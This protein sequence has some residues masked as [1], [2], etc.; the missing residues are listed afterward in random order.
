MN[1][2]F[3]HAL[4]FELMRRKTTECLGLFIDHLS[5]ID[6]KHLELQDVGALCAEGSFCY[7]TATFKSNP[8]DLHW[9]TLFYI[10]YIYF[11]IG[12]MMTFRVLFWKKS[13]NGTIF[14]WWNSSNSRR[15]CREDYMKLLKYFNHSGMTPDNVKYEWKV[16]S[17]MWWNVIFFKKKNNFV[18]VNKKQ[19]VDLLFYPTWTGVV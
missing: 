5:K 8:N 1:V 6:G 3:F 11:S 15:R 13:A 16:G 14:D 2:H 18:K 10:I 19:M 17:W 4:L 7:S 9:F 12:M